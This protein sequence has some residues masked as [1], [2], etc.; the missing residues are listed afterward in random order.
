[1]RLYPAPSDPS[2]ITQAEADALF[3]TQTEADALFL[4][5]TESDARYEKLLYTVNVRD[6]QY[7][8]PGTYH[9]TRN[10][11]AGV[12][13]AID[14]GAGGVVWFPKGIYMVDGLTIPNGTTL[15][16]AGPGSSSGGAAASGAVLWHRDNST[17]HLV[18]LANG[19]TDF[20]IKISGM[21]L[22]GNSSAQ[23]QTL[24]GIYLD[25]SAAGANVLPRHRIDNVQIS[26]CKGTGL[27]I[28]PYT[29]ESTF[30]R[31]NC[32]YNDQYGIY[33]GGAD[34][35]LFDC[36]AGQSGEAGFYVTGSSYIMDTCRSWYSG[37]IDSL[38]QSH[39][40]YLKDCSNIMMN[41]CFSQENGGHGYM[42]WG[43]AATLKGIII[44]GCGSDA[45]N[46]SNTGKS[47]MSLT[48]VVNATIDLMVQKHTG[49]AGTP[50]NMVSFGTGTTDCEIRLAGSGYSG[51][52]IAGT[53]AANNHIEINGRTKV[54]LI[55]YS[56][57]YA[58]TGLNW[59]PWTSEGY[60]VTLTGN[61][62]V[63]N[64][65][66]NP[67]GL[68]AR[69]IFI[70]DA[71]AGRT[72]TFGSAFKTSWTPVTTASKT[73]VITFVCDGTNW[74]QESVAVGL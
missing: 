5:Q 8:V 46:K 23:T 72:V 74:V 53:D 11:T 12:Q 54:Q 64:P 42:L 52:Q 40:F 60:Q 45:D 18:R 66:V 61:M 14:A 21:F 30:S 70:Q 17:N 62:I 7:G 28:G 15:I 3:L 38:T 68:K 56:A 49:G 47:A 31:I 13:A 67:R 9:A 10:D 16:G 69:F 33:V 55:T 32:Y 22:F 65:G 73:N 25:N 20:G 36:N 29:R 19:A 26:Q 43:S 34:S 48:N 58:T 37:R 6:P 57:G 59:N 35:T 4:T 71:T 24:H 63:N 27:Y 39:G 41:G 50:V 1:M 44:G 51:Y 2:A